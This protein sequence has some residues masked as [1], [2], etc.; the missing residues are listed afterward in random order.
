MS[1]QLIMLACCQP[2]QLTAD[3]LPPA[4]TCQAKMTCK[5]THRLY[6]YT[7]ARNTHAEDS[8]LA[9]ATAG[10]QVAC[11]WKELLAFL[12][13]SASL[14]ACTSPAQIH[15]AAALGG[16][17]PAGSREPPA[18]RSA[19]AAALDKK[20]QVPQ[21]APGPHQHAEPAACGCCCQVRDTLATP[22][23]VRG[24]EDTC[25]RIRLCCALVARALSS[26]WAGIKYSRDCMVLG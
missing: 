23:P 7:T 12:A 22:S 16:G 4:S 8:L 19:C 11:S 13:I 21:H 24:M 17:H 1:L 2:R 3:L 6:G 25:W 10:R 18:R 15:L 26:S 9:A 5:H 14:T 20:E